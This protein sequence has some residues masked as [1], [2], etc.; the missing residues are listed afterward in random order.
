M[1]LKNLCGLYSETII[2]ILLILSLYLTSLESYLLFHS[3]VELVSIIV[4]V[5]VFLITWNSKKYL[6]N[7]YLLFIG[8]SF[9]FVAWIDFLHTLSY[10]G[11]GI[12]PGNDSNLPTQLWIAARYMQSISLLIAPIAMGKKFNYQKVLAIYFAVTSLVIAVIFKGY[13][14]DCYIEGSGLTTCKV[15]SEYI[16]SLILI[17]SATLLHRH[18]DE[19][20]NK[21]YSLIMAS[22]VLTIFSELT[23]TFYIDVYGFS[24]LVGHFLKLF[25]FYLIYKAIVVT[26]L[27]RPYD[28]LYRE[29]KMREYDLIKK[30]K[31]Q[32]DLL[33]TLGLVNKIL[34]HDVLNDLNIISLLIENLKGRMD[35]K[36][37]DLSENAVA[38]SLKLIN[39]MKDFESLIRVR[40]LMTIDLRL[41]A[42]EVSQEFPANIK[43]SGHC[44]VK[45]DSGLHSVIGNIVQN[46]I[47]HGGAENI[48]IDIISDGEYCEMHISDDGSG[49]PDKIKDR[50]FDEGFKFGK[51]GH[52][53]LGLYISKK[54]I[55]RYGDISVEDNI[56]SGATFIIRF[57]NNESNKEFKEN[58]IQ[59]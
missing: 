18:K 2:V 8:I 56:P 7:S 32:D 41:L 14:P 29:L 39:E 30:K 33:E 53:G 1:N 10:K 4:I 5:A 21:V 12:F 15:I 50:I 51:S 25:S 38:H 23:F 17:G 26:S 19:F 31:D 45:A 54:I 58:F 43:V 22:I 16:I 20:D 52:T 44:S 3:I 59:K 47:M 24:N 6:K 13:F 40:E 28:L 49:I 9:F 55:E 46:A 35:E 11:M 36:E 48:N 27:A 34:R 57:F 42:L 37:L